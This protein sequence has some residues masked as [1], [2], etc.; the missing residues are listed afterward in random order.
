MHVFLLKMHVT[1]M[2]FFVQNFQNA[3]IHVKNACILLFSKITKYMHFPR[4]WKE[5][6][7]FGDGVFWKK[8][9]AYVFTFWGWF[10]KIFTFENLVL[11]VIWFTWEIFTCDLWWFD[12][13]ENYLPV[14]CGDLIYLRTIYLW[15]VVIWFTWELF[16]CDLWWFDSLENYL[17]VTCGDLIYLRTIYLWLVYFKNLK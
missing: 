7:S 12:S 14:T 11:V 2:P 6:M 4:F 16:T 3:C 1:C 15:L 8:K 10:L 17:P 9:N 13:L 5:C